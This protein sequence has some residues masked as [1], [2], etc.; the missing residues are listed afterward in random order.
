[1]E[2]RK[3]ERCRGCGLSI[4]Q[5]SIEFFENGIDHNFERAVR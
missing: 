1:L 4:M 2:A 3:Q 5:H